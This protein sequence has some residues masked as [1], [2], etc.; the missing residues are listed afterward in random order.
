MT[1]GTPIA[2]GTPVMT[3][4]GQEL[5][6]VKEIMGDCFKIDAPM[7]PDYWLGRDAV[8]EST[9]GIIHLS[10]TKDYLDNAK[11]EG[12]GHTGYHRHM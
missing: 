2:E 9:G 7:Q 10:F 11:V 3:A 5:G 1:M 12:P 6:K 4:D 8:T